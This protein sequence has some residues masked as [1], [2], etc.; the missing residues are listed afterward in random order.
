M[1]TA[2]VHNRASGRLLPSG[3]YSRQETVCIDLVLPSHKCIKSALLM[4]TLTSLE[5]QW[6]GRI[7]ILKFPAAVN[8]IFPFW[9]CWLATGMASPQNRMKCPGTFCQYCHNTDSLIICV[10]KADLKPT[11]NK[12]RKL[13][14][15]T[16]GQ[17]SCLGWVLWY[18]RDETCGQCHFPT[19]KFKQAVWKRCKN[20]KLILMLLIGHE[21]MFASITVRF[22]RSL[23][24]NYFLCERSHKDDTQDEDAG[25]GDGCVCQRILMCA[26]KM[27]L[28]ALPC[29]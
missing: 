18:L 5:L 7:K 3:V 8:V 6:T 9:F 23:C 16:H 29:C 21:L 1:T 13:P 4:E 20:C 12:E 26:L 27:N 28:G 15:E 14:C 22:D 10:Y 11:K 17:E 24:R 2:V 19:L 25:R